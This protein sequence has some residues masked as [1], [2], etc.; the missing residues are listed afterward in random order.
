M[1]D[2]PDEI[3]VGSASGTRAQQSRAAAGCGDAGRHLLSDLVTAAPDRRSDP[4]GGASLRAVEHRS[5][6]RGHDL[7]LDPSPAGVD[8]GE[9]QPRGDDDRNAVGGRQDERKIVSGGD[10]CVAFT[11][12]PGHRPQNAVAVD[13]AK[14]G[15][16]SAEPRHSLE[17][18]PLRRGRAAT[19]ERDVDLVVAGRPD[20]VPGALLGRAHGT[21][22][23]SDCSVSVPCTPR[24]PSSSPGG[25]GVWERALVDYAAC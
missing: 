17:H 23:R 5:D 24:L 19:N 16:G 14:P 15:D 7:R 1:L 18:L 8:D 9:L 20:S 11:G 6:D 2:G 21:V 25:G 12:T 13:L 3:D 10:E 22:H 4:R